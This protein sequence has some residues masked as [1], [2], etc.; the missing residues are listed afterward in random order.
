M[1]RTSL[2]LDEKIYA[3]FLKLAEKHKRSGSQM[4]NFVME[5]AIKDDEAT[6]VFDEKIKE[7]TTLSKKSK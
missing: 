7:K 1:K 2:N 5:Q 6:S 3:Q 4:L